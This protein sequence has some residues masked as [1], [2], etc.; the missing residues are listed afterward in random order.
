MDR[1]TVFCLCA[2]SKVEG[3]LEAANTVC[4]SNPIDPATCT[5]ACDGGVSSTTGAEL[6]VS[7]GGKIKL[8]SSDAASRA[9]DVGEKMV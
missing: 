9:C 4:L 2:S 3:D 8:G 6:K 5:I 7:S 1:S